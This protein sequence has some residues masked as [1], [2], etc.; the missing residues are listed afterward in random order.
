MNKYK[1]AIKRIYYPKNKHKWIQ[2]KIIARSNL[3]QKW[4]VFFDLNK[5]VISIGSEKVI[6]PYFCPVKNKMR[7]YYTDMIVKYRD[8]YGTIQIKLIEIKCSGETVRPKKPKRITEK[9]ASSVGTYIT[10]K[11]KWE[12]ADKFAKSQGWEFCI[13]TEKDL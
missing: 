5:D 2:D 13:L 11:A 12:A 3:E 1:G 7:R 10:N 6:V 4:F 9:Y 8:K